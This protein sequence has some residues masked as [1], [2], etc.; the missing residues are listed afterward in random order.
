MTWD[1]SSNIQSHQFLEEYLLDLQP[2]WD[3]GLDMNQSLE[4]NVVKYV[5]TVEMVGQRFC[6]EF[7]QGN[8]HRHCFS[9]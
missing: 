2:I 4:D 6:S 7:L 8:Y 1:I 9:F 5:F 3:S